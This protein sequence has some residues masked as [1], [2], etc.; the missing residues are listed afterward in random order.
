MSGLLDSRFEEVGRLEKHCGKYARSQTSYEVE[1]FQNSALLDQVGVHLQVDDFPALP[2][3]D[4]SI[5][6]M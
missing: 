4:I 6:S 1:G 5:L 3:F 2:P